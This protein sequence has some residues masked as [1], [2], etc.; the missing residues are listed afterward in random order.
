MCN[1]IVFLPFDMLIHFLNRCKG[2]YSENTFNFDIYLSKIVLYM[3]CCFGYMLFF[4]SGFHLKTQQCSMKEYSS[5]L[6]CD[7]T[8]VKCLCKN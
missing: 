5:K 2:V 4:F 6:F 7:F 3:K 8:T 1:F